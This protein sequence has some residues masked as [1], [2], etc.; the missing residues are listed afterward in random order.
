MITPF[1][2]PYSHAAVYRAHKF[3][4]YL[5][6]FG[7]KPYVLTVDRSF[8]Y[9]I[10]KSLLNDLPKEVEI[11]RAKHIDLSFSGLKSLFREP[12]A[13]SGSLEGPT[14]SDLT[15]KLRGDNVN[16]IKSAIDKLMDEFLFLPDRYITW[17]PFAL[18]MAKGMIDSKGVDVIYSTAPPF[19]PHLIAMALKRRFKIPWTA[20]FRDVETKEERKELRP[21]RFKSGINSI[22]EKK[23]MEKA[24]LIL[25]TCEEARELFLSKYNEIADNKIIRI[26]HGADSEILYGAKSSEKSKKFRVIFSG[27]FQKAYS[28]KFFEFLKVIFSRGLFEKENIEVLIVGSIKR[29]VFLKKRIEFL[30]LDEVVKFIDYLSLK[31]YFDM[32]LS[33]DAALLPSALKYK[34]QIKL[35]DYLFA[36]KPIIAFDVTNEVRDILKES[37]LGVFVPNEVEEGVEVILN[38]LRGNFKLNVNENYINQF[39]AFNRTKELS[40]ALKKLVESDRTKSHRFQNCIDEGNWIGLSPL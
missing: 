20:D 24:D 40:D 4:K 1:F 37:G 34:I 26:M 12:V 32:L 11:L 27:E 33:A 23:V 38:L 21:W 14:S 7:W 16:F 13:D 17:Y 18:N 6:R 9:F 2:A 25:T 39:S 5:P 35:S 29:N 31:D 15:A 28:T 30:G 3:A 19:T 8:L 10:D 22:I 36:K